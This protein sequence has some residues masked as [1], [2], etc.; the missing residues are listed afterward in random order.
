MPTESSPSGPTPKALPATRELLLLGDS[1][2]RVFA[3]E[4]MMRL[5]PHVTFRWCPSAAPPC[6]DGKILIQ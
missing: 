1:Q 6:P 2:A 5:L 4:H 3:T